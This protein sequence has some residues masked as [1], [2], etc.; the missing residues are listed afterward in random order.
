MLDGMG[1]V[2]EPYKSE[3]C[4]DCASLRDV[5]DAAAANI[6][7]LRDENEAMKQDP[8]NYTDQDKRELP[9][10]LDY[11]KDIVKALTHLNAN[12]VDG[13]E[14]K[15]CNWRED[16]DNIWHTGCDDAFEFNANGPDENRCKFCLYCG[17]PIIAIPFH[18][19]FDNAS[20]EGK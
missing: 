5:A 16:E 17:K 2:V 15:T 14:E 6:K 11:I 19:E 3:G 7:W 1:R 9:I 4:P 12:D 13:L 20:K 18:F 10:I 8:G